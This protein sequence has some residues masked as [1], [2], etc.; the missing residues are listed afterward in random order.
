MNKL[1]VFLF[2]LFAVLQTSLSKDYRISSPNGKISVTVKIDKEIR[3]SAGYD[4]NEIITSDHIAMVLA[5]G[6]ILG[7]SEIVKKSFT[8]K[9]SEVIKP[10]IAYKKSE[11]PDIYNFLTISFRTGWNLTFRVYDDG[12]AYRFETFVKDSLTVKNELSEL[13]FPEGSTSWFPLEKSF[14]SHNENSFIYSSLDTISEKNLAS[15]P[16]L[17]KTGG[18]NVLV[19]EACIEDYPG[20]WFKG[21]GSDKLNGVWPAYPDKEQLRR[22][23]DLYVTAVKDYIARTS[24][25][26]SFPWRTFVIT[27]DDGGLVESTLVYRLGAPNRVEDTGWIKPGKVAWDWWNANNV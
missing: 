21:A 2:F 27:A 16:V 19:T 25:T 12:I 26:R 11:I 14:M 6:K 13:Q 9:R 15:L 18:V 1:F 17:F 5:D 22:D 23:R 3:W 24:G 20:M 10:V 8:G 4:N 7:A